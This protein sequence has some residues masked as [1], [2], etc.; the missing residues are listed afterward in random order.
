MLQTW[1]LRIGVCLLK[2]PRFRKWAELEDKKYDVIKA[3]EQVAPNLP[4]ILYAYLSSA[5]RVRPKDYNSVYWKDIMYAF[6][7]IHRV[8]VPEVSLPLVSRHSEKKNEKDPWDYSGRLW[9]F[10]SNIIA[11]AY[12]W[13]VEQIAELPVNTALA[14]LQEILTE[15][16]LE[17]E[18]VWSTSEIAYPYN[19]QTKKSKFS[20]LHRPYWMLP[21]MDVKKKVPAIPK[22]LLPVGNVVKIDVKAQKI[23]SE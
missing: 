11:S 1:L 17:R 16:Q 2:K 7:M 15:Q 22:S 4:D 20:P 12:G 10:Y 18:F 14:Y 5:L 9:F 8:T 3:V 13:T 19:K 21:D 23:V 6:S